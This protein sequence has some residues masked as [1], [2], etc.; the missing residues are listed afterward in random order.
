MEKHGIL[1]SRKSENPA[2]CMNRNCNNLKCNIATF[3]NDIQFLIFD[4]HIFL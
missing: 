1:S 2:F 4:K 3:A